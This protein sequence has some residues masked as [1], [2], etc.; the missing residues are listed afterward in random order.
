MVVFGARVRIKVRVSGIERF[1]RWYS[2]SF[3][4]ILPNGFC[5]VEGRAFKFL[6][7]EEKGGRS[8]RLPWAF[9]ASGG[10]VL[11]PR[12]FGRILSHQ[13]KQR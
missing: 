9:A 6:D 3:L 13:R 10:F 4:S 8:S 5:W 12:Y 2:I 11:Q 1:F 7:G